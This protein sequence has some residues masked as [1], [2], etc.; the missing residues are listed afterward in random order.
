MKPENIFAAI[1]AD[2]DNELFE[3]LVSS[4][5]VTIEKIIS[6]GHQSP[7]RGWY[8]QERNEWVLVLKGCAKLMFDDHAV[9][10]LKAGDFILIPP[11]KKHKVSWTDPDQET[12]WLAVYF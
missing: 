6:K 9:V 3:V 5:N 1:P 11:H 10:N 4:E 2:L 12:V 7:E 8:D